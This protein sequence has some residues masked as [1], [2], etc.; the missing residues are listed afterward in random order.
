M[1]QRRLCLAGLLLGVAACCAAEPTLTIASGS[2]TA[3]YTTAGLLALPT[4]ATVTIPADVAYKRSMSYRAVP[5]AKLLDGVSAEDSVRF[6]A[7]DGFVATLPAA[8]L[9]GREDAPTA[10]LA[11]EPADAPWPPLKAGATSTAGPF[12]L[13]WTRPEKGAVTPEQWPYQI[14]R[15]DVVASITKRFPMLAPSPKLAAN[16]PIRAG[17]LIFQTR[18]LA[19][20]T[21]NGGGDSTLGPDLNF[22]YNPTEYMRPE[23]LRRMIR[24]PQSLHRWPGAKM[25]AFDR[26]TLSDRELGELLAYL[27]HMADRKAGPPVAK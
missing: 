20:H 17:F 12:Y 10:Y 23:A 6:T 26:R 25:P 27:R 16:Q 18:C 15:I 1:M 19:C 8:A 11:V 2:R 7:A 14:A 4:A 13:V 9:L 24:D 22:P 3:I 5:M 21:L